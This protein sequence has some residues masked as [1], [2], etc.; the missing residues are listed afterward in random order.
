MKITTIFLTFIYSLGILANTEILNLVNTPSFKITVS[1]NIET[2]LN[3]E[4]YTKPI[5]VTKIDH[6]NLIEIQ[7]DPDE[8]PFLFSIS[9]LAQ[10]VQTKNNLPTGLTYDIS[11]ELTYNYNNPNWEF[12]SGDCKLIQF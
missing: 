11:C 2:V 1:Q 3:H 8:S 4:E 6:T 12:Y 7:N 10:G 5:M 9:V